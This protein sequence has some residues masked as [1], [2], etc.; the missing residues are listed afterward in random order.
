MSAHQDLL[1][2]VIFFGVA[3]VVTALVAIWPSKF[4]R[5]ITLGRL[6]ERGVSPRMLKGVRVIGAVA[7]VSLLIHVVTELLRQAT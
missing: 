3:A 2:D 6:D 5:A 7:A 4:F 1:L